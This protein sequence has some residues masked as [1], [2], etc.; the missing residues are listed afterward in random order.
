MS[1]GPKDETLPPKTQT[2]A[3]ALRALRLFD[4]PFLDPVRRIEAAIT[5][6]SKAH[7]PTPAREAQAADLIHQF[8][9]RARLL[10]EAWEIPAALRETEA[11]ERRAAML[12][13]TK[14]ELVKAPEV[15]ADR[16]ARE[17]EQLAL[18]AEPAIS[19]RKV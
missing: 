7:Y 13:S 14:L 1:T 4:D 17:P 18:D 9:L 16:A 3:M 11:F 19:N 5:R 15:A 8:A 2:R 6:V 10:I 12:R